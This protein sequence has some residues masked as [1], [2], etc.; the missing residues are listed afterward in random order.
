MRHVAAIAHSGGLANLSEAASLVCIRRLSV[1]YWD[2]S[3]LEK[4]RAAVDAARARAKG[5]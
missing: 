3:S 5:V 4:Q 1:R 2:G